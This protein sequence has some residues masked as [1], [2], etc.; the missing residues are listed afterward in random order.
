MKLYS[1]NNQRKLLVAFYISAVQCPP[2]PK[3]FTNGYV[4]FNG[5]NTFG[6]S[7]F[8]KC[9]KGYKLHGNSTQHCRGDRT[10]F[11]PV[12]MCTS[13]LNLALPPCFP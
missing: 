5:N 8:Y 7:A 1:M 4:E 11:P 6:S 9:W 3:E 10:W 12:P 2:L 13:K